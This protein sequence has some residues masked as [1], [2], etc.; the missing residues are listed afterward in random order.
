MEKKATGQKIKSFLKR[1]VY[2]IIMFV[3]ILAIGA[4][5]TVAVLTTK[6]S[7]DD[8]A[9]PTVNQPENPNDNKPQN[10][11]DNKPVN[12]DDNK[13]QNPNDNKPTKVVFSAPVN[14]GT[15]VKDYSMDLIVYSS[16]LRQ[17]MV[18]D[19][20]DFGGEEGMAVT[21][22]Y[23]GEV[24]AVTYDALKGH[25][26]VIN[27][28]DG[29]KTT[30]YSLGETPTVT[31]GQTVKQGDTLGV[32]GTSATSEML[33]GNHVHFNVTLNGKTVSPYDYLPDSFE[34]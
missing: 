27:H 23:G 10:P 3:S 33:D 5:V 11:D 22:V 29:L 16:T 20:I 14:G 6:N 7:G 26:V 19:G 32:I 34:K 13:P 2:Y 18:H 9:G 21:A 4:M 1:N 8:P 31:V 28:G 12:P 30:Y 25:R 17:Y 24:E 15:L